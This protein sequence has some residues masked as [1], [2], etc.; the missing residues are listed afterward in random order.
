MAEQRGFVPPEAGKKLSHKDRVETQLYREASLENEHRVCPNPERDIRVPGTS[1][2]QTPFITQGG[3]QATA[4][5]GQTTGQGQVQGNIA[6]PRDAPA[7]T[8]NQQPAEPVVLTDE[9]IRQIEQQDEQKLA[10]LREELRK[11][12]GTDISA[13][14]QSAQLDSGAR[15]A[16]AAETAPD[17]G[18]EYDLSPGIGW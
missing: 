4:D 15:Q 7:E 11:M 14:Q 2:T 12:K 17:Q 8:A 18:E 10:E 6:G 16:N 9:Q 13:G 3:V 5:S 1:A